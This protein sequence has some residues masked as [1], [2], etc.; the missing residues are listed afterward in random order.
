MSPEDTSMERKKLGKCCG[1]FFN[2]G[3]TMSV[4]TLTSKA[5]QVNMASVF[6][7]TADGR[8]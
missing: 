8:S 6:R 2:E 5:T 7:V 1:P 4:K 3:G